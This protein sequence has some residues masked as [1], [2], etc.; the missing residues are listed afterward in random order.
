MCDVGIGN[1]GSGKT[2]KSY[3]V[4]YR[5]RFFLLLFQEPLALVLIGL[6]ADLAPENASFRFSKA[7][8][9]FSGHSLA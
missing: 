8:S 9:G 5:G 3:S 7:V 4:E 6:E 1:S 2:F